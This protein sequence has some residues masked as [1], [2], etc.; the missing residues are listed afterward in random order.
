MRWI[1]GLIVGLTLAGASWA[2]QPAPQAPAASSP[3]FAIPIR[4]IDDPE[5]EARERETLEIQ[6]RAT[7]AAEDATRAAIQSARAADRSAEIADNGL[8]V[9]LGQFILTIISAGLLMWT[10]L[11]SHTAIKQ[12]RI[13]ND[14]TKYQHN[15]ENRAWLIADGEGLSIK[16]HDHEWVELVLVIRN[17]GNMPASSIRIGVTSCRTVKAESIE[18]GDPQ[19]TRS[20]LDNHPWKKSVIFP[21]QLYTF[22]DFKIKTYPNEAGDYVV[23]EYQI[24]YSTHYGE[25]CHTVGQICF[26]T[27]QGNWKRDINMRPVSAVSIVNFG[28]QLVT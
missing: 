8:A 12:A 27:A 28:A 13:A 11:T 9:A 21:N 18:T 26:S 16:Y 15:L 20:A 25:Q 7:V 23:C 1:L 3:G 17:I 6:R 24:H 14:L 2:Q 5:K 19:S 10:I 4:T 22:P